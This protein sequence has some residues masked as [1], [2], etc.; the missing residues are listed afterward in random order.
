M[1]G[2][3][4]YFPIDNK[5]IPD[6][7]PYD[8][9]KSLIELNNIR[10]KIPHTIKK[11]QENQKKYHDESHKIISFEA[12]DLVVI[13]FPFLEV[14]KSPKLGPKYRGPFKILEKINDLNYKV[15]LTLNNKYSEDIIHVRRLKPYHLRQN[16]NKN[17]K[18]TT[19]K[20]M[21]RERVS[22]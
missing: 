6:S 14:G 22:I 8:L 15:Q 7:L 5:I 12:G 16:T 18:S 19:K 4:P 13:K 21:L 10:N 11:I 9:K 20:P 1:H 2:F 17:D 3:E